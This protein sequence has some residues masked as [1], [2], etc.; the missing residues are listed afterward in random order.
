MKFLLFGALSLDRILMWRNKVVHEEMAL[1]IT[2]K[3]N[4]SHF[5]VESDSK[6]CIDSIRAPINQ[7]I[8]GILRV[9]LDCTD[10][11]KNFASS[12]FSVGSGYCSQD[13]QV[14]KNA[15]LT[16]KLDSTVLFTLLKIILLHCFQFLAINGIQ[17][18]P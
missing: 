5:V 3:L 7:V 13:P 9:C 12:I 2:T 11:E 15:N 1:N 10:K 16:L 6:I 18:D 8:W 14:R 17:T 4:A